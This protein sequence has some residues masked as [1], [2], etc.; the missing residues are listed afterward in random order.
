MYLPWYA[1]ALVYL[2]TLVYQLLVTTLPAW[3]LL[4]LPPSRLASKYDF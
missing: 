2:A 3:R 4:R 1:A